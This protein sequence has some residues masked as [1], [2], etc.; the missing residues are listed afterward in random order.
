MPYQT[1][2]PTIL[3]ITR[4]SA[5]GAALLM[6][7]VLTISRSQAA[8]SATT[9]NTNNT[10]STGSISLTDDDSDAAMFTVTNMQPAT[11]VVECIELTYAGGLPTAEFRMYGSSTGTLAGYL[12]TTVE[13]GTGGEFGDCSS[14]VASS[15]VY[16]DVLHT[17]V[18]NN[19]DY[20]SGITIATTTATTDV[21]VLRFTIELQDDNAAQGLS[22]T[23]GFHFE[24][25]G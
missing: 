17:F 14:F 23:I 4:L 8:F 21:S 13:I 2:Q 12:D 25:Q 11:P 19:T 6:L 15:T 1:R 16:D 3:S 10:F 5:I 9:E 24:V 7:T 20:A 22:A 18:V